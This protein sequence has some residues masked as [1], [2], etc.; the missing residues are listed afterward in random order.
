[1]TKSHSEI[2]GL[3]QAAGRGFGFVTPEG[4]AGREE[5]YFIPPRAEHGAWHGDTVAIRPDPGPAAPG[6]KRTAKV[7]AILRRG[8]PTVTGSVRK[9]G[10]EAWLVPVGDKLR[11]PIQIVGKHRAHAGDRAAV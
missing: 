7:T 2:T 11:E 6:E 3:Y 10:R 8:N 4:A 5:D 9:H 1:M